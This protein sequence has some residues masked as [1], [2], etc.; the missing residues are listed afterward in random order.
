MYF[1]EKL[2]CKHAR[3]TVAISEKD[4]DTFRRWV[5][6]EKVAGQA[7]NGLNLYAATH[8]DGHYYYARIFV[9]GHEIVYKTDD[10]Y[11][12]VSYIF[13]KLFANASKDSV[14]VFL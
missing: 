2:A 11:I 6:E 14:W 10:L 4:A 12:W 5:G 8:G 3:F 9:F 7:F 13:W 1:L